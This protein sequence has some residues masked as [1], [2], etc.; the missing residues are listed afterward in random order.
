MR[1]KPTYDAQVEDLKR[2]IAVLK[3]YKFH[4]QQQLR[5]LNILFDITQLM[6]PQARQAGRALQHSPIQL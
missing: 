4:D 1:C 5:D 6:L 3:L 2:E